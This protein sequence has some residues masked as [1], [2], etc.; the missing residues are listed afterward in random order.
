MGAAVG[1]PG[2]SLNGLYKP[3]SGE[4]PSEKEL[5]EITALIT[6]IVWT[7]IFLGITTIIGGLIA[8]TRKIWLVRIGSI[9]IIGSSTINMWL[10]AGYVLGPVI[11]VIAGIIGLLWEP[12]YRPKTGSKKTYNIF[13][14]TKKT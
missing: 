6:T 3:G 14:D 4:E 12:K 7:T 10:G 2:G 5:R 13:T 1:A 8:F 11:G 9:L